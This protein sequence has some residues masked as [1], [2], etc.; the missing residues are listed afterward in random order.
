MALLATT[1]AKNIGKEDDGPSC[2]RFN[3]FN[4]ASSNRKLYLSSIETGNYGQNV[5]APSKFL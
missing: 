2:S 3:L 1:K 5:F 4:F